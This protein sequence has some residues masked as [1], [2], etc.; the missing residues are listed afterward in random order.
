MAGTF[1]A[2]KL[3][4][5]QVAAILG[6]L[7]ATGAARGYVKFFNLHNIALTT[8]IVLV[9]VNTRQIRRIELLPQESYDVLDDD[10]SME[11]SPGDAIR[12][13]TTNASAVDFVIT[14]VEET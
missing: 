13:V 1:T 8:E 12:A 11:L 14:G 4:E 2:K 7:Y 3:A 9:Y 6:D 5:G 10:R